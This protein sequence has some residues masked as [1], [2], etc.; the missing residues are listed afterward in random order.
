MNASTFSFTTNAQ[1]QP[2]DILH[3]NLHRLRAVSFLQPTAAPKLFAV[4]QHDKVNNRIIVIVFVINSYERREF[5]VSSLVRVRVDSWIAAPDCLKND[6]R[7]HTNRTRKEL[8]LFRVISWIVPSTLQDTNEI[9]RTGTKL[10]K[11]ADCLSYDF[12]TEDS[13]PKNVPIV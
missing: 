11:K 1:H 13:Q 7:N 8:V 12:N 3:L 2:A 5:V 10:K 4:P 9:T 6:P